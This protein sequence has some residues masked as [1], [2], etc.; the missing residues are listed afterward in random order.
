MPKSD[1]TETFTE[2]RNR[3]MG[4]C[5]LNRKLATIAARYYMLVE[6]RDDLRERTQHQPCTGSYYCPPD[7][8][9]DE[10]HDIV[11]SC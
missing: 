2:M 6:N 5:G 8:T 11:M 10:A 4:V 3:L 9:I 7:L 1:G